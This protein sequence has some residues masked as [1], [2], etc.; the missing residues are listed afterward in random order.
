MILG[1]H[2]N[3]SNQKETTKKI[4]HFVFAYRK[5]LCSI[6]YNSRSSD[7]AVKFRCYRVRKDP[8]EDIASAL[9]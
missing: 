1:G 8:L 3:F 7:G 6:I 4:I 9:K 5:V 2:I